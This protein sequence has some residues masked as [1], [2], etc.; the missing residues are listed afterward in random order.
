[1][2]ITYYGVQY[3]RIQQGDLVIAIDPFSKFSREKN[4]RFGADVALLSVDSEDMN[5]IENLASGGESPYVISGPGEYEICGISFSGFDAKHR[6]GQKDLLNTIY[7]FTVDGIHL[8]FLGALTNPEIAPELIERMG[9]IDVL[10]VPVGEGVLSPAEAEKV[11]VLLDAKIIIP[12]YDRGQEA[13]THL[14]T[15][16]KEAGAES[17]APIEKLTLKRKDIEGKEGEVVILSRSKS[18]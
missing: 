6:F 14:Q 5:G 17:V 8:C 11:A 9:T 7:T 10:F 13:S 16:L 2:V 3:L 15:F 4:V 12:M 1:M 18:A